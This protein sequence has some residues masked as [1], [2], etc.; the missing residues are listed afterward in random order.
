M[1]CLWWFLGLSGAVL[2]ASV[3]FLTSRPYRVTGLEAAIMDW[4]GFIVI[5]GLPL[6]LVIALNAGLGIVPPFKSASL[7]TRRAVFAFSLTLVALA[8]LGIFLGGAPHSL[9]R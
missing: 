1:T 5:G 7:R 3:L 6:F 8:L 9:R 4:C 2:S